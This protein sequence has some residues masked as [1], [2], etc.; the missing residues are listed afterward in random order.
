MFPRAHVIFVVTVQPLTKKRKISWRLLKIEYQLFSP[1]PWPLPPALRGGKGHFFCGF[2]QA[3]VARLQKSYFFSPPPQRRLRR[4]GGGR[5]WGKSYRPQRFL[6][7]RL[8]P[9]R[10]AKSHLTFSSLD[11]VRQHMA[12]PRE[13]GESAKKRITYV[14][15]WTPGHLDTWARGHVDTWTPLHF[16]TF[17]EYS[18][19]ILKDNSGKI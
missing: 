11:G 5:G 6:H 3:G 18:P 8:A 2:L 12:S 14:H 1:I 16:H 4:W 15:T 7:R 13:I 9:W 17:E 10:Q 19:L